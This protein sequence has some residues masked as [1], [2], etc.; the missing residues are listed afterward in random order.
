MNS[1]ISELILKIKAARRS[2]TLVSE[3]KAHL[4]DE[5]VRFN[6]LSHKLDVIG[7]RI[8][9]L[10]KH[11]LIHNYFK[12][13]SQ[14]K[15]ILEIEKD[16]YF[17]LV[18]EFNEIKQSIHLIKIQIEDEKSKSSELKWLKAEFKNALDKSNS[19]VLDVRLNVY[20]RIFKE[21]EYHMGLVRELEE[22]IKEGVSLNRKFNSAIKFLEA[23]AKSIFKQNKSKADLK[24]YKIKSVTQYHT[25]IIKI[26]HNLFLFESEVND[27]YREILKDNTLTNHLVANFKD[28]YRFVLLRDMKKSKNLDH[29]Y[30]FMKK[31]KQIHMSIVRSLRQDLK[32]VKK[33]LRL[34]LIEEEQ[35]MKKI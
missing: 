23:T 19:V 33:R 20:K 11:A 21:I 31:H 7:R 13:I 5:T 30:S 10:E 1:S 15:D 22:A 27:V 9:K 6:D 29:S 3:L 12:L 4:E 25:H 17:D 14:N 35:M 8:Q 16:H 28:E 24:N 26:K 2:K 18:L 34:L 32:K